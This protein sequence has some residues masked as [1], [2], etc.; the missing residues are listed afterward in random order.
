MYGF[1]FL[2]LSGS[3]FVVKIIGVVSNYYQ[4]GPELG[5]FA[6]SYVIVSS[7]WGSQWTHFSPEL[8]AWH[9][10]WLHCLRTSRS[11]WSLV[12]ALDVFLPLELV[13]VLLDFSLL[14]PHFHTNRILTI[15]LEVPCIDCYKARWF[16]ESE[17][18]KFLE[19]FKFPKDANLQMLSVYLCRCLGRVVAISS[20]L[21]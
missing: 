7:F 6:F 1:S 17:L 10:L 16:L 12:I 20:K 15:M 11:P 13:L 9:F 18:T 2:L 21:E 5:W 4:L 8:S 19:S 3:P 14:R